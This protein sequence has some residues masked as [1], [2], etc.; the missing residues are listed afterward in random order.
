MA[1]RRDAD[2]V[3]VSNTTED[4]RMI[5][6][7]TAV[8]EIRQACDE[9]GSEA[10][11]SPFFFVV[12][13]GISYPPVP[14]ASAIVDDCRNVAARYQ[15]QRLPEGNATL[16]LYSHWFGRAYPGARQRQEYL[17]KLIDK[18]PL[19]LA[20]LRLA[21]LLSARKLTNLVITTNFDDFIAR[22]LRLFGEEPA[23]CDHPRTVG[24]IDRERDGVQIVHVHGSYLFYDLANLR[25]E[26]A[27]RARP[28]AEMSFTMLGLLDSLLWNRS[29][30]VVGYSGWEGDIVMSALK[31]RLRG[32]NP[33][34]QSLYWFAYKRSDLDRLPA[35]VRD[36]SDV[37][38]VVPELATP[39]PPGTETFKGTTSDSRITNGVEPSLSSIAVF[40][41]LNQAF[42][43]GPP[44][45]FENPIKY[46]AKSLEA[47]LP[48]PESVGGDPYAFRALIQR[49]EGVAD[50]WSKE[51]ASHGRRDA[52][53]DKLRD[54]ASILSRIVP[55]RLARLT[56]DARM[57]VLGYAS[58][59]GAA[60]FSKE[61]SSAPKKVAIPLVYDIR[62]DRSLGRLPAGTAW[63]LASRIGHFGRE[64][65]EHGKPFGVLTWHLARAL[66]E[67]SADVD[68]DGRISILE[69]TIL[70]ARA[71]ST[72]LPVQTPVVAGDADRVALFGAGTQQRTRKKLTNTVHALLVGV[73]EFK[74][75]D[76]G[77][78]AG[79]TN[80]VELMATLLA[81]KERRLFSRVR[82]RKLLNTFATREALQEAIDEIATDSQQGDLVL[83]YFSG[84]QARLDVQHDEGPRTE[85]SLVLHDFDNAGNGT[86]NQTEL[87]ARLAKASASQTL[88]ILDF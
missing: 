1:K 10:R 30:L 31:R 43:I 36:S 27:E 44:A 77:P 33:L 46:F 51:G 3:D 58:I 54:A 6:L 81:R 55:A 21:H 34:P 63:C 45:L 7:T 40:D 56:D 26:L 75:R 61:D 85:Y 67:A 74:D 72:E 29:P 87:N 39:D 71:M 48:E 57:E 17:R 73:G 35:W 52:P 16:D 15:R 8:G 86:L 80:D 12:G 68:R 59:V 42:E 28:D 84:H 82:V 83:F 79:P 13:A 32:G 20:S 50:A 14:L 70:T 53:L 37:R 25:G 4:A 76:I 66:R 62:L 88:V 24:R 49:L 5:D 69:A 65:H 2:V 23:V 19:S 64:T 11:L 22:A 38:F 9:L 60:L 47:S 78:L 41:R 18:K